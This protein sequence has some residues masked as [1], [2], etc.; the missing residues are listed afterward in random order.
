MKKFYNEIS[1]EFVEDFQRRTKNAESILLTTHYGPD[2][3]AISSVLSVY[4]YLVSYL[5]ID[6]NIIR[7]L[8]SNSPLSI[9]KTFEHFDKIEF[10]EDVSPQIKDNDLIILLDASG[11]S[12]FTRQS[13]YD[14]FKN[15]VICIDHHNDPE[16]SFDLHIV[17]SPF[18]SN[19]ELIYHLFYSERID[20]T[21]AKLIMLGIL[22]D[23][24]TF[25]YVI[26]DTSSVMG[27]SE[28]LVNIGKI[29]V[30]SFL[31]SYQTVERGSLTVIQELLKNIEI[32][33]LGEWPLLL[34]SYYTSEFVKEADISEEEVR[35]GYDMFKQYL[36][37]V[38]GVPWG[39]VASPDVVE[40]KQKFSARSLPGTID[41][42]EL[43]L[44]G[45]WGR[46]HQRAAG[47]RIQADSPQEALNKLYK[48]MDS[49][50]PLFD[51]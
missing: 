32:K 11:W 8:I 4:H 3:D 33:K 36:R 9:W 14:D 30:E 10:V 15:E 41:V 40:G 42:N 2:D 28:K 24:G 31:S 16:D 21:A 12:R 19:A 49:N 38:S 44:A 48:W 5:K 51:K 6:E 35:K 23:T 20:E 50:K 7:I 1:K 26:P 47:G 13:K 25:R 37:S 22:G 17:V 43:M 18:S 45:E 34:T 39:I 29:A 46:G 27:V